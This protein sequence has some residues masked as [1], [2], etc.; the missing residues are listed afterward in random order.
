MNP[1]S[2]DLLSVEDFL[3]FPEV[4]PPLEYFEGRVIQKMSPKVPH[5]Y[6]QPDLCAYLNQFARPRRLG[7]AGT[8][9]RCTFGGVSL[10]FDISFYV[11][12]RMPGF[13]RTEEAPDVLAA[14]DLAVEIISPGQTVAD[15]TT[16][17]RFATRHGMR[18]GWLIHLIRE[19]VTVLRPRRRSTILQSG[20]V[21]SGDD[22]LPGFELP[23]DELFSWLERD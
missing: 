11:H 17:L 15:Q 20:G 21:L 14:P 22:V 3:T 2:L 9:M 4:R 6:L 1:P 8:E 12:A 13:T 19:T 16:R 10:V 23:L 18:I 7:R 5:S